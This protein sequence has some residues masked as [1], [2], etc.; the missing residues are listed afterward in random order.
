MHV[1]EYMEELTITALSC[2]TLLNLKYAVLTTVEKESSSNG[3]EENL[4]VKINKELNED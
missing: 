2:R 4:E 1:V 3:E